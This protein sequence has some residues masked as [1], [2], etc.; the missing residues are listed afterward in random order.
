M[1]DSPPSH[2]PPSLPP[3]LPAWAS[4]R[5]SGEP[6]LAARACS[7]WISHLS[8]GAT[9]FLQPGT[10]S[11]LSPTPLSGRDRCEELAEGPNA[12]TGTGTKEED[13]V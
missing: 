10:S 11:R 1:G 6:S 5:A 13:R 7:F 4:P 3:C 8:T 9:S 2:P 12:V